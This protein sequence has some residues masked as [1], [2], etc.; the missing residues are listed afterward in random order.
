[1]GLNYLKVHT[2]SPVLGIFSKSITFDL[3][4]HALIIKKLVNL[5]VN[6]ALY[7]RKSMGMFFG[8]GT[9]NVENNREVVVFADNSKITLFN[10]GE[11][12]IIY[13]LMV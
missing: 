8:I 5:W 12:N 1:M 2:V 13:Q 7:V 10:P 4:G 6:N 9:F 11:F 3:N